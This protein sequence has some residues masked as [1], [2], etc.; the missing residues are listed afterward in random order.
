[1]V[2]RIRWAVRLSSLFGALACAGVTAS[3][4][5]DSIGEVTARSSDALTATA[6]RVLGLDAPSDWTATGATLASGP[7]HVQGT[8][9]LAVSNLTY[10]TVTSRAL[11]TL[12]ASEIGSI[13]GFDIQIPEFQP[14]PH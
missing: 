10:A 4:S 7:R 5:N 1:M 13:V 2:R 8:G 9:S 14:N 6:A 11:S 3:C 12:G